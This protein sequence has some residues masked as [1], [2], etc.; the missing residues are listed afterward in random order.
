MDRRFVL[1]MV[2]AVSV[3]AANTLIVGYFFPPEPVPKKVAQADA[4][5][6]A[7]K[8]GDL[9]PAADKGAAAQAADAEP[10]PAEA[11]GQAQ[12]DDAAQ[13][14]AAAKPEDDAAPP[15]PATI[16]SQ[17]LSLG[18]GDPAS[19]F[20]MLVYLT[21]DGAAIERLEMNSPQYL[22]LEDRSGYLGYLSPAD[23][24]KRGG[25]VVRVVGAGSPAA[26]AGLEPGDVI[27]ALGKQ[28]IDSA[29]SL[30]AA[31]APTKPGASI[32]LTVLR[33]DATK[34][35]QA[36]LTRQPLA[37]IRPEFE[38]K[39]IASVANGKHDPLS[40]LM[41]LEQFDEKLLGDSAEELRDVDLR[42][43]A[44]EIVSANEVVAR[45]RKKLPALGLELTKTYR[46]AQAPADES[47][48]NDYPAYSLLLDVA[49]TN[50]SDK[51][52]DVAYQ[53]D[54]PT[55]LPTEGSWYAIK[56]SRSWGSAGLRDIIARFEGGATTQ[57]TP[58][59]IA[60]EDFDTSWSNNPLDYIAVDAQYFSVALVP[61]AAKAD[62]VWFSRVKPIRV[63][64][65]PDDKALIKM[66]DISFRLTSETA[67]LAPG[68]S[69]EH[70][71]QIFAGPKRPA[72]LAQYAT[73]NP[74]VTL[75][76]LVYYGWFGFV[77]KP[78]LFILHAFHGVV[79]NYGLAIIMLTVAVRLCMFPLSRKQALSAQKMQELQPEIKRLNEKYKN[80]AEKKM[81]AQQDLFKQHN[82]HPL[83]GCM[84]AFVQLPIFVGLYRSLSV[85]VSLRQAPLISESIRWA[86]NLAAPDMFWDWSY[87]MPQF[88]NQG[89]GFF[90]LGPYLNILPLF[91]IGLFI[92]QQ[93]MF[94][95]PA[96]DEQAALQQKMMQYMMI[97]MG[98]LFF[99]VAS[100]LCV[101]FIASSIWGITER[102]LLPKAKSHGQ[103][104]GTD[105]PAPLPSGTSGNG[106]A[107]GKKRQKGRK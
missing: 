52:H 21:N 55:G 70:G 107:R 60:A 101:Y 39:P 56:V 84:L 23:A 62:E 15:A 103:P 66:T 36:T 12:P 54:G 73:P 57:V 102:K 20:R 1:F 46:L 74:A 94:M 75:S 86:S 100:G 80:E 17:R 26:A 76:D 45:F 51:A 90:G 53:L 58:A 8:Q 59:A 18:S 77:A 6:G 35:L 68:A 91:T 89:T 93:K 81:R 63:G 85:D 4:K 67:E 50:V 96:A 82:Y 38:T 64:A 83:G 65:V 19:P 13:E 27:T 31:L 106:A 72:L 22:D 43:G 2:L 28:K 14:A 97:F 16:E 71:F 104:G 98:L 99:K 42:R 41:T 40:F 3:M 34:T 5:Q 44:W 78:M 47:G 87:L 105:A 79:G 88:I 9:K 25:A 10:A 48:D 11:E 69:I 7:G 95:P 32:E 61:K 49:V 37:V 33:G 30:T 24:S 92:W 29:A